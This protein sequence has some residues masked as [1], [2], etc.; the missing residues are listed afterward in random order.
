MRDVAQ[1]SN[2]DSTSDGT[3]VD[4]TPEATTDDTT[5]P[6]EATIDWGACDDPKATDDTLECATLTVPL[7]Y[8]DPSGATVDL[9]LVRVP[10]TGDRKGAVVFNPGGPGASGFD[11]IAQSGTAIASFLGLDD[12]DL[13]GFDPRGVD[14][15]GGLKCVTDA[16]Q[17]KYLYLDPT[18]DTPEEQALADE[19][20]TAF[21]DGCKAAYGDT[22]ADYSTENTA[23][24]IDAIRAG[25]GDDQLSYLGISYGTYLGAVYA[26]MFPDR[27]RSMVLD[28]AYE[29]NGDTI[30]EHYTTQLVGFEG[31]FDNWA[32]YCETD[33]TCPFHADDVGARWDALKA[34]LDA[35]PA[36]ATDGREGNAAVMV[37]ATVASLYSESEWPVLATALAS[38]EAGD[39]SGI[40]GLA[41]EYNGRHDDGTFDTLFQSFQVI[42]CASGIGDPVPDD[43]QAIVDLVHEKAP[44]FGA[45]ATVEQLVDSADDCA[46][47]VGDV[48]PVP[49]SYD[50]DGP[51]LVVGGKNDPA[52]PFQYAE[53]MTDELGLNAR[54]LTFTGE[55]HGQ[56]LANACVTEAEAAVLVDLELPADGAVCNPDAAIEEPSW[57]G[58]IPTP[59][60]VSGPEGLEAVAAAVGL[61]DTLAYSETRTTALGS[62]EASD[63]YKTAL[64]DAGFQLLGDQD[65]GIDDAVARGYL[66]PTGEVLIVLA[67]GPTALQTDDFASVKDLV[68]AGNSVVVLAFTNQTA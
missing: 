52:T 2:P 60:G 27:V 11:P 43:P 8:D 61:P 1:N 64:E 33:E 65:I 29:P 68:P 56:L 13:I 6:S 50:G 66:S 18:P 37:R 42:S 39:P 22:L 17:D 48:T 51:I 25:L 47:M 59:D 7:D 21:T 9:A 19:A 14:R 44:R 26:S 15:S 62:T 34:K 35:T 58:D 23:R 54:L 46:A 31:A 30:E 24:D 10:A 4:P 53:R 41:D 3:V 49:V 20:S 40:F 16:V 67:L 28:S 55:G 63:A 45:D 36:I 32:T 5:P 12:F 57:W 38:A